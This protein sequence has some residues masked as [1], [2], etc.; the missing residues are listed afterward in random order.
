MKTI[1]EYFDGDSAAATKLHKYIL[2]QIPQQM[3]ESL[4]LHT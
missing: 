2:D 1:E 3:K 4:V